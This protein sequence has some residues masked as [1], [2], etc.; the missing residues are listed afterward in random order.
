[1]ASVSELR[2]QID[3]LQA[4][5]DKLSPVTTKRVRVQTGTRYVGSGRGGGAMAPVYATVNET[6]ENKDYTQKAT[7]LNKLRDQYQTEFVK[8]TSREG[9]DYLNSLFAPAENSD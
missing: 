4:E 9:L 2:S 3:K 1:M 8:Q 7:Q 5:L 6:I